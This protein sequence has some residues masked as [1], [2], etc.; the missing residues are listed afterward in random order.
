MTACTKNN[1]DDLWKDNSGGK[2]EETTEINL[3]A[4]KFYKVSQTPDSTYP[5]LYP[6][7]PWSTGTKLT[8]EQTASAANKNNAVAWMKTQGVDITVD[9]GTARTVRRMTVHAVADNV[10][11]Y[12]LP[13]KVR[14]S[15]SSDGN[16]WKDACTLAFERITSGDRTASGETDAQKCRY[17][18]FSLSAPAAPNTNLLVDEVQVWGEYKSDFKYVPRDGAYHGAFNNATSFS[19][20]GVR[21]KCQN[22]TFEERVGKKTSMVLWYQNMKKG[23]DFAEIQA[24]RRAYLGKDFGGNWRF[25]M[26]GWSPNDY[27][28][29]EVAQGVLDDYWKAYFEEVRRAQ[30]EDVDYGPVWFRPANEMNSNWVK[31]GNDAP[32]FVKMWRR[33]YNMA[34]QYGL[35]DYNVFVW[36]SADISFGAYKMKDYYPG[37]Q[38]VDWLGTSCYFSKAVSYGYPSYLMKETESISAN[39]PVM[40]SE[41]GYGPGCD[42]VLWVQEWFGLKQSHPRVKAVVWENHENPSVGDRRIQKDEAALAE[43]RRLVQD[44][45]WLSELPEE[46]VAEIA[47]RKARQNKDN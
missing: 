10:Q 18:R 36:S 15:V 8:D 26:Y 32:S 21:D 16:S 6:C 14:V 41:G 24:V 34:E 47:E 43:Y 35:T 7:L 22:A 3:A 4:G 39:K 1:S 23:R 12:G 38:Y 19:D 28:A 44:S 11:R 30:G 45:Y 5:D 40:I 29:S 31:Y 46:V 9:L 25:F 37:D 33:L 27:S 42:N 17:V 20:E 2:P 13:E